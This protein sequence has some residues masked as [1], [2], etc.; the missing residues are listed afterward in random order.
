LNWKHGGDLLIVAAGVQ[1]IRPCSP[2]R[3]HFLEGPDSPDRPRIFPQPP[4]DYVEELLIDTFKVKARNF[5]QTGESNFNP[6]KLSG[7]H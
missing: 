6:C 1:I 5:H 7:S 2:M 4:D 3:W